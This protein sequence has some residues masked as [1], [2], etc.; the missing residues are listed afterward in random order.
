MKIK[1]VKDK[2]FI[3]NANLSGSKIHMVNLA[4]TIF[5]DINM[6]KVK[7]TNICFSDM[8][9]CGAQMGGAY[10]HCIGLPPETKGNRK[11]RPLKFENCDLNRSSIKNCDLSK[12]NISK[13]NISGLKINGVLVEKLLKK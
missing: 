10:F 8:E 1:D 2:L 13:C 11:Q 5:D 7:F 6:S 9:I 4:D 3:D 12:V